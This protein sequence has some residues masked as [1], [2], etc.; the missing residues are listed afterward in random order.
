M[1][2]LSVLWRYRRKI[3]IDYTKIDSTL[4]NFPIFVKISA[5]SGIGNNDLTDI[6]DHLGAENKKIAITTS[7]GVTECYTEIER[8]DD[9]GEEAELWVKVPSISSSADTDLYIYYDVDHADNT[10]YIGDTTDAAAQAVWDSDYKLVAHMAQDPNG[11]PA[12]GILDS[13]TNV[14]HGTPAGSMTTDDLVDSTVGQG[15]DF[16]G[17][18]D[19]IGYTAV[20]I[21]DELTVEAVFILSDAYRSTIAIQADGADDVDFWLG[22]GSNN[23]GLIILKESGVQNAAVCGVLSTGVPIYLA[24]T[25]DG[26]FLNIFN[27]LLSCA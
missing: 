12:S 1:A 6:F 5:S 19:E 16:D 4:T 24:G 25:Y 21:V 14:N 23:A 2:W 26:S 22:T 18:D 13:T 27:P 8:W 15:I 3:T 11:D 9:T 7:D 17:T 20:T 10:T